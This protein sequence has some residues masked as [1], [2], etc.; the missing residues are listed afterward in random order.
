MTRKRPAERGASS[1]RERC[2]R[3]LGGIRV[4]RF[5]VWDGGNRG[6]RCRRRK[7][8]G[9]VFRGRSGLR[10][11]GISLTMTDRRWGDVD[12]VSYKPRVSPWSRWQR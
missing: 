5:L 4:R 12:Q 3:K 11:A 10:G 1:A 7:G 2:V 9:V 8:F 6:V